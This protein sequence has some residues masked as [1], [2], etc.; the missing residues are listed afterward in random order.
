MSSDIVIPPKSKSKSANTQDGWAMLDLGEY[1]VHV[2]SASAR[3]KWFSDYYRSDKA[4]DEDSSS[5][6]FRL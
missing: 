6:L 2:L 1:A 3:L 5:R 4:D